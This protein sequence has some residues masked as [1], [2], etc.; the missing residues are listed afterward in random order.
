MK[1]MIVV[2]AVVAGSLIVGGVKVTKA[3]KPPC[4]MANLPDEET[5]YHLTVAVVENA[6]DYYVT[7][8][9]WDH[10]QMEWVEMDYKVIDKKRAPEFVTEIE[11]PI[12]G[13]VY[14]ARSN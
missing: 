6:K 13:K 10:T 9:A 5:G 1:F 11:C 14:E 12:E 7:G 8:N 2:F 3:E 4:L